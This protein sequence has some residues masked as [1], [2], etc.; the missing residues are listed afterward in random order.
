MM[1]SMAGWLLAIVAAAGC[2]KG[3]SE[4]CTV[5]TGSV[6]RQFVANRI[7]LPRNSGDFAFDLNGDGRL[8]NAFG[9]LVSVLATFADPQIS[10]DA[11]ITR[12]GLVV[13]FDESSSD[14]TFTTDRCAKASITM[15]APTTTAPDFSGGGS[16]SKASG[17]PEPDLFGPIEAG[18]FDSND[19]SKATHPTEVQLKLPL[20][21]GIGSAGL[22]SLPLH[23]TAA[24]L[25]F[26]N[27]AGGLMDGQIHGAV[28][29]DEIQNAVIPNV[30]TFFQ[31]VIDNTSNGAILLTQFD[32]G[33]AADATCAGTGG[34]CK[35]PDGTCANQGDG[36]IDACEVSTNFLIASLLEPDVQLFAA[37][38]TTYRPDPGNEAPDSLSFGI[39]FTAVNASF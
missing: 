24:H 37:D 3:G 16:F 29:A 35:N 6:E 23:L 2:G 10:I 8:D 5:A 19:P 26:T 32:T 28:R 33:G 18:R 7:V 27:S 14:A 1:K 12:G 20:I 36:K 17:A 22:T 34:G 4:I 25:Q 30:A 31:I 11:S 9:R 21:S 38:K 15:G 39:G 13:L